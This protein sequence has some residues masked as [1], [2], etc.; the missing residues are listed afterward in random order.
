MPWPKASDYLEEPVY[1]W[2]KKDDGF[3]ELRQEVLKIFSETGKAQG[4]DLAKSAVVVRVMLER[5]LK[6]IYKINI[7]IV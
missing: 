2:Q 3:D 5:L 1:A 4:S 6:L 7:T